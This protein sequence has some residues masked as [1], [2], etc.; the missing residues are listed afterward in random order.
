[1]RN[2]L[3]VEETPVGLEADLPQRGQVLEQL[4][5][6]EVASVVNGGFRPQC[7]AFFVI[8]LD[9]CGFVIDMQRLMANRIGLPRAGWV[10][11][12]LCAGPL[13]GIIYCVFRQRAK[14]SLV[15]AVWRLVGD[16][17]Q[18]LDIRRNRLLALRHSGLVGVS[19]FKT[20]LTILNTAQ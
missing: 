2:P 19:V 14:R 7:P 5:D 4:A 13:A 10:L 12:S 17:S 3:D 11:A 6:A 16:A 8:L 18:P 9:P 1:M 20:C 15:N